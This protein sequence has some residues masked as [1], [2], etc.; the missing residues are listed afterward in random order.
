MISIIALAISFV[1]KLRF[2]PYKTL[3]SII[4]E[5]Y[6]VDCLKAVRK[7]QNIHLKLLKNNENLKF[8][9][10][11]QNN[12]LTP[13]FLQFKLYSKDIRN[14]EDYKRYQRQLLTKE[15]E[16][17]RA[18][19]QNYDLQHKYALLRVENYLSS[20]DSKYI[21]QILKS[22]NEKKIKEIRLVHDR[23]LHHL[24]IAPRID[25][26]EADKVISNLSFSLSRSGLMLSGIS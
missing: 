13:K 22:T 3:N 25:Q 10:C 12:Q 26:I 17:K 23:K 20:L 7:Y 1:V 9:L 2:P 21:Q 14:R 18:Y 8:L 11:C 16:Q 24:G 6:G 4:V 5:R 15:I 19:Q